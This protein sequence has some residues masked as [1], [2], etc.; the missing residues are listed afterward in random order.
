[1]SPALATVTLGTNL[2]YPPSPTVTVC[3]VTFELDVA[4]AVE[5]DV[6]VDDSDEDWAAT[7]AATIQAS[8]KPLIAGCIKGVSIQTSETRKCKPS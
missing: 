8:A 2:L 6:D 1:M 5:E 7:P 3:V 4:V